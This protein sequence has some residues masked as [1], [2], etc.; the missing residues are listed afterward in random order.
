MKII[1]SISRR[2]RQHL[3][4]TAFAVLASP[5]LA[6]QNGLDQLNAFIEEADSVEGR[7]E[8]VVLA[9]SGGQPQHAEG[10]FVFERPGKFRWEYVTPYA[11]LLVSNGERLWSWDRDLNQVVVQHLGDA[12]GSTPAAILAGDRAL[13]DNFELSE[14]GRDEGFDWVRAQPLR[15]DSTFEYVRIGFDDGRLERM[16]MRDHFGQ[17]TV[18]D[19]FDLTTGVD[20]ESSQFEFV[21]PPGADVMG[22]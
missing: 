3:L 11:Q 15:D 1:E 17:T 16:E 10:S 2:L 6:G 7:F 13:R 12:L 19:F 21:P 8:Q 5:V 20:T 18:I 4:M 22:E 9:A 14:D